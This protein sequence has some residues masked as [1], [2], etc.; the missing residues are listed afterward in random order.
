MID[1][2]YDQTEA[3]PAPMLSARIRNPRGPAEQTV[4]ALVDTG[5]SVCCISTQLARELDL[6]VAGTNV[7]ELSGGLRIS[8]TTHF[9]DVDIGL[10]TIRLIVLALTDERILGRDLLSR[11]RLVLDGPRSSLHI[12]GVHEESP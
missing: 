12:S 4:R 3:P 8:C 11:Y 5:S 2:T 1:A 9:A 7:V 6:P 10:G